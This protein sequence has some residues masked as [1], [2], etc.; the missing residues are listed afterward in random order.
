MSEPLSPMMPPRVGKKL[1]I[2][3][4]TLIPTTET[5]GLPLQCFLYATR[6]LASHGYFRERKQKGRL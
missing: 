5:V 6:E 4:A 1:A 3:L 2:T